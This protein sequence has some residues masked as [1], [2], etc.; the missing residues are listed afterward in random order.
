MHHGDRC[1]MTSHVFDVRDQQ[2]PQRETDADADEY[3]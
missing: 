3:E 1:P 2:R